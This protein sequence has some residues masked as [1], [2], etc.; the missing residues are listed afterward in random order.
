MKS[1]SR[2]L[3]ILGLASLVAFPL[4]ATAAEVSLCSEGGTLVFN[5][6]MPPYEL[7]SLD[8]GDTRI[9]PMPE[10]KGKSN[11]EAEGIIREKLEVASAHIA[12]I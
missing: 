6:Q 5:L 11:L 2:I 9:V 12:T 3:V 10:L 8:N 7:V 4:S 1:V